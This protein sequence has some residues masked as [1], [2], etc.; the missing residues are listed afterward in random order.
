MHKLEDLILEIPYLL[1]KKIPYLWIGVIILWAW[2]P[3]ISGIL[4]ALIVLGL[5]LMKWQSIAWESKVR[6]ERHHTGAAL[7]RDAPRA[8]LGWQARNLAI[9]LGASA[10]LGWMMDGRIGY[11]GW[12]MFLLFAGFMLLY[13]DALLLGS[14]TT[15]LVT[16]QGIG[17]HYIPGHVDYRLFLEFEEIS[18][19][20]SIK[21][22]AND[23]WSV[24]SPRQKPEKGILLV[25]KNPYGFSPRI[26]F[27]FL[28]PTNIEAFLGQLPPSLISSHSTRLQKPQ[29][30]PED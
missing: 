9:L 19:V 2:P 4:A 6:R 11:S 21:Y 8:P 17:I 27:V 24:C 18:R 29:P 28:T 26:K 10:V 14:P 30:S 16:E 25:P 3:A 22:Q 12:Q 13:R 7:Y 15:Y 5:L 23:D 20:E 1:L